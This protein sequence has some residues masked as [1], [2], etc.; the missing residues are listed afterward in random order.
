[1]ERM[2]FSCEKDMDFGWPGEESYGLTVCVP[3]KF[4]T[5]NPPKDDGIS[6]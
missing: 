4:Y 1:M 3:P 5:L 2:H 6:K